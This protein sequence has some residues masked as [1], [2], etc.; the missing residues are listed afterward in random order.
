MIKGR[1]HI[2]HVIPSL[3]YGGAERFLIDLINHS[4]PKRFWYS[5]ILFFDDMP[6]GRELTSKVSSIKIV[7]KKGKV[8]MRLFRDLRNIYRD[9]QTDVVH[10][11]LFGGDFWGRIAAHQL[12]LPVITTEHGFN[13]HEGRVKHMMRWYLK[14]YSD[15]YTAPSRVLKEYMIKRYG[16]KKPIEVIPHGIELDRFMHIAP[17]GSI[18][19]LRFVIVGRLVKQKG[20]DIA[21]RALAMLK[22]FS[23]HLDIVGEGEEKKQLERISLALGIGERVRFLPPTEHI[24]RL[25]QDEHVL[26]V[27]SRSDEGFGIVAMEGMAAGRLVIASAAGGL[28]E[29]IKN[30][31]NGWLVAP[32]DVEALKKKLTWCFEE[33]N[34]LKRIAK[35]AKK[36]AATYFNID[37]VVKEYEQIY[38]S[39][40]PKGSFRG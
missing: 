25:L 39:L 35:E 37:M 36:Y 32:N 23:W 31:K 24:P 11:H 15:Y 18:K 22:D 4:D 34:E 12:H 30:G 26:L 33:G 21:L 14:N 28:K 40:I 20:H 10:T 19:P 27:P 2:T 8:S 13:Q 9:L 5:V 6:L 16:I 7:P 38:L 29:V 1:I 17:L 3:A